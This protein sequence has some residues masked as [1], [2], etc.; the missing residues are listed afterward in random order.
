MERKIN[1]II[2]LQRKK[3]TEREREKR[4]E[5]EWKKGGA[6]FRGLDEDVRGM[7]NLLIYSF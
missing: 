5:K 3:G 1:K 7:R 2:L 6:N 4:D